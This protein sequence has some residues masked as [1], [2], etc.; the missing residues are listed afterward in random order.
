[1][2]SRYTAFALGDRDYL[3]R[4]WHRS[5]RPGT[6]ELDPSLTWVG[7]Q[8]VS[9]TGGSL[10]ETSGTVEF[11]ASYRAAGRLHELH[12]NSRFAKQDGTWVYLDAV[13]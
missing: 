3:L 9:R 8:I 10:L 6:L 11:V 12:E 13:D 7:L 5:T 2:R 4:T 1:M